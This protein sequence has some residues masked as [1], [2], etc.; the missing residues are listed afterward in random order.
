[1]NR[2]KYLPEVFI[3]DDGFGNVKIKIDGPLTLNKYI[4]QHIEW[5]FAGFPMNSFEDCCRASINEILEELVVTNRLFKSYGVW[6][7][8]IPV[9]DLLNRKV[10]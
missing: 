5:K 9:E 4:R 8:A 1:M 2:S 6:K 7:F 10:A 3:N